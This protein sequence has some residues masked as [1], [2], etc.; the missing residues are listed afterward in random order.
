MGSVAGQRGWGVESS[1]FFHGGILNA[2]DAKGRVSLP[3]QLRKVIERRSRNAF[4]DGEDDK[5]LKIGEFARKGCLR[6]FDQSY[7]AKMYAA[8]AASVAK[9]GLD[10]IEELEVIGEQT[11]KAFGASGDVPYDSVGRM[12]L[13]QT[14][15]DVAGIDDL[16]WFVGNADTIQI[17]NPDRF[18]EN[19]PD[20]GELIRSLDAQLAERAK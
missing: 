20:Q 13:P 17:W 2:V 9:Q 12:V 5:S 10:P 7:S 18:R 6:A 8:I 1:I 11:L 14:L 3:I 16:A 19:C 4:P 15:R